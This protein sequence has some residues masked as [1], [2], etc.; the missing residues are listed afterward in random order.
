MNRMKSRRSVVEQT[1][2]QSKRKAIDEVQLDPD[3]FQPS[4]SL[5]WFGQP[6]RTMVVFQNSW[7]IWLVMVMIVF[8]AIF[9]ITTVI[10]LGLAP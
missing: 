8:F 6:H 4:S 3:L 9:F 2:V 5:D 7:R 1:R 10:R